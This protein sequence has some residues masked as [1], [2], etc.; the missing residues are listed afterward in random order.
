MFL[1]KLPGNLSLYL[2]SLWPKVSHITKLDSRG[3]WRRWAQLQERIWAHASP[4]GG[5]GSVRGGEKR[6]DVHRHLAVASTSATRGWE[7]RTFKMRLCDAGQDEGRV[8]PWAPSLKAP[9]V[10]NQDRSFSM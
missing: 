3:A 10:S 1:R 8:R 5:R 6:T 2:T 4:R 7:P 9:K